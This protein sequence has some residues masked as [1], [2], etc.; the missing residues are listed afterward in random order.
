MFGKPTIPKEYQIEDVPVM[1]RRCAE[2]PTL[3]KFVS[4]VL[5]SAGYWHKRANLYLMMQPMYFLFG[6]MVCYFVMGKN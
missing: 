2:D 3:M 6:F 5:I 4:A 1:L